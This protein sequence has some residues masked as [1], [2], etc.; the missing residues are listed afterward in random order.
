VIRVVAE[1][2]SFDD[3]PP[4]LRDLDL[5]I[6]A[7]ERIALVGGNGAGKTTLLR[8]IVGLQ[9]GAQVTAFGERIKRPGDAVRAGIGLVFQSPDDQLFGT[10]VLDDVLFGPRNLGLTEVDAQTRARAA[11]EAVGLTALCA[12]RPES[13][14]FGEKKRACLA[15]VLAMKPTVLLLDEPTAGLDPAGEQELLV[16]L[17]RLRPLTLLVA[18]HA[19]DLVPALASRVLVLDGG[20]IAAD[21]TPGAVFAQTDLLARARLRPPRIAPHAREPWSARA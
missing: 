16:L 11:L 5:S 7:G 21:G 13:L 8:A 14:S 3:A 19:I 12:R 9:P 20:R 4:V 6:D 17:E 2:L 15:G 18:T 1:S 10:T